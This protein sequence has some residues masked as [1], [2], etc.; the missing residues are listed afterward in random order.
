MYILNYQAISNVIYGNIMNGKIYIVTVGS[1]IMYILH[2]FIFCHYLISMIIESSVYLVLPFLFL[3][4][5]NINNVVYVHISFFNKKNLLSRIIK[6]FDYND[7]FKKYCS[8]GKLY[9][10][11]MHISSSKNF[12]IL[13]YLI[14]YDDVHN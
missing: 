11:H 14:I 6:Y 4:F 9:N 3:K 13:D 8:Q 5:Q 2:F 1:S 7:Y 10:V 12:N